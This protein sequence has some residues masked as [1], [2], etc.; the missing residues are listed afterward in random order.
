MSHQGGLIYAPCR[1]GVI[2]LGD[3]YHVVQLIEREAER[4]VSLDLE[5]DLELAAFEQWLTDLR[6]SAVIERFVEQ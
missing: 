6:A 2:Q 5:I 3:G 4:E 1:W